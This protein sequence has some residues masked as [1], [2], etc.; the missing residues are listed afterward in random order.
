MC[1]LTLSVKNSEYM[2]KAQKLPVQNQVFACP[3]RQTPQRVRRTICSPH[4]IPCQAMGI[5]VAIFRAAEDP[6]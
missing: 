2:D 3:F 4:L 1:Q 5:E 6:P